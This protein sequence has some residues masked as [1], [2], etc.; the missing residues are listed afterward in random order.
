M[1]IVKIVRNRDLYEY[2]CEHLTLICGVC[3]LLNKIK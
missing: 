2:S 3:Y 1:G